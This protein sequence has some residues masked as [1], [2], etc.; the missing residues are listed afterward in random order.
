MAIKLP[1]TLSVITL[2]VRTDRSIS[3]TI[4]CSMLGTARGGAWDEEGGVDLVS[5][6]LHLLHQA[7]L[8]SLSD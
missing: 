2:N 6:A 3:L 5:P 1:I 4:A 8:V 7:H